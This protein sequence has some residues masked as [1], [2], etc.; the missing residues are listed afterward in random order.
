[1]AVFFFFNGGAALE[2]PRKES[3]LGVRKLKGAGVGRV[4]EDDGDKQMMILEPGIPGI[5]YVHVC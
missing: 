3:Q 1:M 5:W 2:V 4:E